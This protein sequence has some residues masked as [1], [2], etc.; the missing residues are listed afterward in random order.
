VKSLVVDM[1][2]MFSANAPKEENHERSLALM[3]R[4]HERSTAGTLRLVVP[5]L[6]LFEM[7]AT[8]NRRRSS[9]DWSLFSFITDS[10]GIHMDACD[11]TT[12]EALTFIDKHVQRHGSTPTVKGADLAYLAAGWKS[13]CPVVT[14]DKGMLKYAR[15]GM[16][17]VVTP[18]QWMASDLIGEQPVR[19]SFV[20]DDGD[21][22][23]VQMAGKRDGG[24][25]R[26]K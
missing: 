2:V 25:R 7:F 20:V 6:Y 8:F 5:T 22:P 10:Q 16:V 19:R 17:D 9:R 4:V 18:T 13:K 24:K 21:Y 15:G 1:S 11:C 12:D 23:W 26:P 3:K 14:W